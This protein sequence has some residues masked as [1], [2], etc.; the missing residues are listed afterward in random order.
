VIASAGLSVNGAERAK[1]RLDQW[2]WFARFVKS[3]SLAARL[4]TAGTLAINDSPVTKPNQAVRVGDVVVIQFRGVQRTLRVLALGARRG[5]P[6]EARLLY[7]ETEPPLR[8][9]AGIPD[10]VP[11][12]DESG[13]TAENFEQPPASR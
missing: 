10:W 3:R 6:T 9:P 8:L 13:S 4:C 12:L 11:L 2:L 7:E 1:S 5:P